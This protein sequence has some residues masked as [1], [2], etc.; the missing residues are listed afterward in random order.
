MAGIEGSS[1]VVGHSQATTGRDRPN[2]TGT[3]PVWAALPCIVCQAGSSFVD[4]C[5]GGGGGGGEVGGGAVGLP[6]VDDCTDSGSGSVPPPPPPPQATSTT[7]RHMPP[8]MRRSEAHTSEL[9]S[10]MR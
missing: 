2:W 10:L 5:G 8:S 3:W 7:E 9:Q 1:A 4:D 6:G